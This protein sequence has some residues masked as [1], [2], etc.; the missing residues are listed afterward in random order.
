MDTEDAEKNL[1]AQGR[2]DKAKGAEDEN[3]KELTFEMC[4]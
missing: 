4:S 2:K 1:Q 3:A